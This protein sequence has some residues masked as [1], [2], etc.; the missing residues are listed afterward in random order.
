MNGYILR[1]VGGSNFLIDTKVVSEPYRDPL[2]INDM[3]ALIYTYLEQGK[4]KD[5]IIETLSKEYGASRREIAQDLSLFLE[6][7]RGFGVE[8]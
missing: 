5:A 3:G 1:R 8:V 6:R 7:L 2:C 4:D